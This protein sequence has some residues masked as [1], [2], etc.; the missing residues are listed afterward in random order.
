MGGGVKNLGHSFSLHFTQLS[1]LSKFLQTCT[2]YKVEQKGGRLKN[3]LQTKSRLLSIFSIYSI[4]LFTCLLLLFTLL[5]TA[6]VVFAPD[7]PHLLGRCHSLEPLGICAKV[8][9]WVR[10]KKRKKKCILT[11][12]NGQ[13]SSCSQSEKRVKPQ[14]LPLRNPPAATPRQ[15]C[16]SVCVCSGLVFMESRGASSDHRCAPD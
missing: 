9:R 2:Q 4:F 5:Q 6:V 8:A 16:H 1:F 14:E 12:L 15:G 7:L 10:K 11:P 13:R 3:V